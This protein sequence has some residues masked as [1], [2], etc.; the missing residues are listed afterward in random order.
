MGKSLGH[1]N[2]NHRSTA[3]SNTA[4]ARSPLDARSVLASYA[5]LVTCTR[6]SRKLPWSRSPQRPSHTSCCCNR[7]CARY[8]HAA[9]SHGF[10]SWQLAALFRPHRTHR[11]R[12]LMD[13]APHAA[14]APLAPHAAAQAS[15]RCMHPSPRHSIAISAG[16]QGRAWR[17]KNGT[18]AWGLRA[19]AAASS[20]AAATA[21]AVDTAPGSSSTEGP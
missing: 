3:S 2:P 4:I 13:P 19:G 12:R 10:P 18:A 17:S 8:I 9:A 11:Q 20:P 5:A 7:C 16:R 1:L 21:A 15:R 14:Q 6:P